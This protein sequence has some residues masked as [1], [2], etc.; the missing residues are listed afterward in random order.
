MFPLW[1]K[2]VPKISLWPIMAQSVKDKF[3]TKNFPHSKF[4]EILKHLCRQFCIPYKNPKFAIFFST[5]LSTAAVGCNFLVAP[6]AWSH[7]YN[8][9]CSSG[10]R[11]SFSQF[12]HHLTFTKKK[13]NERKIGDV[14]KITYSNL[15]RERYRQVQTMGNKKNIKID[16]LNYLNKISVKLTLVEVQT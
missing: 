7:K 11:F 10:S 3:T 14:F 12:W 2:M 5:F 15:A 8:I 9:C 4:S 6:W 16:I 1:T 13:R